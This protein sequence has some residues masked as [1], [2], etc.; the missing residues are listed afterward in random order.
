MFILYFILF[1]SFVQ[2]GDWELL[3]PLSC[4]RWDL[5]SGP[6]LNSVCLDGRHLCCMFDVPDV[7]S[8]LCSVFLVGHLTLYLPPHTVSERTCALAPAAVDW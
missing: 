5:Q 3:M 1:A 2:Q 8:G 4:M 7:V 6:I